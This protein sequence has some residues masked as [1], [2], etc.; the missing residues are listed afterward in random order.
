MLREVDL[1]LEAEPGADR[2]PDAFLVDHRQHARHRRVDQR[3]VAVGIAAELG[4]GA[5]KQLGFGIHLG[6]DLQPEDD[7]PIAGRALDEFLRVRLERSC[8]LAPSMY[9]HSCPE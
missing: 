1:G 6:V 8:R 9:G 3:N 2:L 7:F 4:R 5:R